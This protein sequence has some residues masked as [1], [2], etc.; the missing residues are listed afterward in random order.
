MPAPKPQARPARAPIRAV[1]IDLDGTLLDTA[2]E[3]AAAA[4][5]MLARLGRAPAA[6]I[7]QRSL[8]I[9]LQVPSLPTATVRDMIGNGIANL[10]FKS[11]TAA[12]GQTPTPEL[13]AHAVAIFRDCYL[14]LLG[15]TALPY[16]GVI[17]GLDRMRAMELPLACVTNKAGFFTEML[18]A[19]TGLRERFAHVVSGDTYEQRKPHPLPLLKTAERF[20]C[21]PHELLMIGDSLND[22]LAAR[23]AGCPVLCVP[24]GYNEGAPVDGLDFDGMIIDLRQACDWIEQRSQRAASRD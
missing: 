6:A 1:A 11:L 22:V 23:A 12:T 21:A 7:D 13:A 18:L 4:N 24:Y 2:G 14:E 16:P 10:V 19:R 17:A 9:L 15:S 8:M 3:I 5:A 20:G